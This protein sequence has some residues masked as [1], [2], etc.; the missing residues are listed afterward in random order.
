MSLHNKELAES[1]LY[2]VPLKA[3]EASIKSRKTKKDKSEFGVRRDVVH[4]AIFRAMRRY[5]FLKFEQM[6]AAQGINKD[7]FK[8]L[9]ISFIESQIMNYEDLPSY[10][11]PNEGISQE[12]ILLVVMTIVSQQL[13]KSWCYKMKNQSFNKYF[14]KVMSKYSFAMCQKLFENVNFKYVAKQFLE[15][16]GFSAETEFM[17]TMKEN[18]EAYEKARVYFL[19]LCK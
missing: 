2:S 7:N 16:E 6:Y 12:G 9:I 3:I 1:C 17:S 18:A 10:L 13:T 15:G 8:E 5:F 11:A 19:E 4:K 14:T